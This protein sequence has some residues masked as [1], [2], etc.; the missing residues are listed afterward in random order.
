LTNVMGTDGELRCWIYK[1]C[2]TNVIVNQWCRFWTGV[3]LRWVGCNKSVAYA[4]EILQI[5][6]KSN[7]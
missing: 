3:N 2:N 6:K 1:D 5:S 4:A 7:K